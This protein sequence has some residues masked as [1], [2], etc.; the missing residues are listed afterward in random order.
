M[1]S[2]SV[3]QSVAAHVEESDS[4]DAEGSVYEDEQV[5]AALA[6][7][8]RKRK[9]NSMNGGPSTNTRSSK[10]P[11]GRYLTVAIAPLPSDDRTAAVAPRPIS[12]DEFAVHSREAMNHVRSFECGLTISLTFALFSYAK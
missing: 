9:R 5:E 8:T 7:S 12:E 6:T 2:V 3:V 4:E 11:Q 10:R 1:H